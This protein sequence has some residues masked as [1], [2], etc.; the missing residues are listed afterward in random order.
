MNVLIDTHTLLWF[1]AGDPARRASGRAVIQDPANAILVSPAS[2]WEI[3]IKIG[4]GKL[5][6]AE[7]FL[8]LATRHYR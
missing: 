4:T 8:D 6:L 1:Y 2:Y 3:A 7:P 5:V